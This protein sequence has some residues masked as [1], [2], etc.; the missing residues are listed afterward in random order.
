MKYNY[1]IL[2]Y[3]FLGSSLSCFAQVNWANETGLSKGTTFLNNDT[4]RNIDGTGLDVVIKVNLVTS[5]YNFIE[6]RIAPSDPTAVHIRNADNASFTL[7]IL[8]GTAD[9]RLDN[10]QN[11][12]NGE[13]ITISNADGG[14]ILITQTN[15]NGSANI[16]VDGTTIAG[17]LPASTS[18]TSS[19]VVRG[20][21]TK[22]GNRFSATLSAVKEFTWHYDNVTG[23]SFTEGFRLFFS[24][25][26]LPVELINFNAI[27]TENNTVKLDWQTAS[28]LNNDFFTLERS[29]DGIDWEEVTKIEGA[30][31]SSS[32]LEYSTIDNNSNTGTT[33]YR[34]KQTDFDGKFEY[35]KVKSVNMDN[36]VNSQITIYPNP[37]S[38]Q[39]TILGHS[40]ELEE[41]IIIN[42]LGQD[43]TMSTRIIGKSDSKAIVDMSSLDS[44]SYFIK[45]K[46]G[47][48]KVYKL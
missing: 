31:N 13:S 47:T 32:L 1:L 29:A 14:N 8:N 11:I 17:S 25:V 46:T 40:T 9:I 27:P 22:A 34:L 20:T 15:S 7:Q 18:T 44:G 4:I 41:V 23:N 45:T 28:E 24:N 42:V 26:S 10:Y 12:L 35:S 6:P 30:G 19:A 5:A 37:V 48:K 39:I 2:A 33:H 36:F 21:G 43:V 38:D 16:T 3:L